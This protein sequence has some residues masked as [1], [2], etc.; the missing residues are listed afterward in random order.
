[1]QNGREGHGAPPP[2]SCVNNLVPVAPVTGHSVVSGLCVLPASLGL[3]AQ[4][5][6]HPE[7]GVL[8]PHSGLEDGA[9][10]ALPRLPESLSL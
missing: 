3:W 4:P 7:R 8:I 5:G 9:V 6:S 10:M 1:M 2:T